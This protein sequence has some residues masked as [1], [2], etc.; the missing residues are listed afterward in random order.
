MCSRTRPAEQVVDDWMMM[1]I[2]EP[3]SKWGSGLS[4]A[5][6]AS[7][8]LSMC[9]F[10]SGALSLVLPEDIVEILVTSLLELFHA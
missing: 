4:N 9:G 6:I 1:Y 8:P 7:L 10:F 3:T 5:D 2:D